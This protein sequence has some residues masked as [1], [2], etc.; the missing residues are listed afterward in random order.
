MQKLDRM[1]EKREDEAVIYKNT[2][3]ILFISYL[4]DLVY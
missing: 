1:D 2:Y 3:Y 4:F